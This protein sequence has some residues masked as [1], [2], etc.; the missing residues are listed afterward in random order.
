MIWVAGGTDTGPYRR[1]TGKS[2]PERKCASGSRDQSV[3]AQSESV[4]AASGSRKRQRTNTSQEYPE[5]L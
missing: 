4:Q 3:E 2:E 1:E 5:G